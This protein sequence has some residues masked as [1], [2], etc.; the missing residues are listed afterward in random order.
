MCS[1]QYCTLGRLGHEVGWKY[2]NVIESLEM[3]RKA[4]AALYYKDKKRD[5]VG[6]FMAP[7][8]RAAGCS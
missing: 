1:A 8:P 6:T 4:K 5:R 7:S 2:Q 3:K